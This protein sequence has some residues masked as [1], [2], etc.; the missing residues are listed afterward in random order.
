MR[1]VDKPWGWE[2]IWAESSRY[3]G[4]T[5]HVLAGKRLSY[6]YHR[7]K[8]EH[9]R[10]LAGEVEVLV[11]DPPAAP[12]LIRLLPGDVLHCPPGR[13]H[14]IGAVVASVL[15]EVSTPELDDVVRLSDDFGRADPDAP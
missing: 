3:V 6:Q 7:Q 14:R 13:R 15:V 4:K 8:E 11:A 10:V 5:L 2:E 1:R 12:A 9:L